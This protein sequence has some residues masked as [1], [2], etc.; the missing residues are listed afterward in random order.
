[1]KKILLKSCILFLF[2][3][4]SSSG[5]FAQGCANTATL[6]AGNLTPPGVGLSTT[7]T[8]NGGQ[9]VLA[10]VIAG[11][12]YTV[13]TCGNTSFDTQL[14]IYNDLS[15]AF[16][17]YNDD[18]CVLQSTVSFTPTFCGNVR[19]VLNQFNCASS[20]SSM[21]VTMTMN[22]AGS[23]IPTL[24]AAPDVQGCNGN[25]VS[26]GIA[27]NGS[28][29]VTPY[30]YQWGPITNLASPT[31]PQT[32][33][34]VTATQSYDLI[35]TDA[36]GCKA[37][38]TVL[39]TM[40]P[41]PNVNLG[42]DTTICGG[43]MLLDAGN[44]GSTY[45]WST[46]QG[47]QTISIS[48]GGTYSV[49][50]QNPSGCINSDAITVVIN[51]NPTVSLGPDTTTC[52]TSVTLNAGPG[53]SSYAWTTGDVTQTSNVTATGPVSVMVTDGNGCSATDTAMVTLSPAPVVN[54]GPDTTQ[55]GGTVTLN[56]GNPG[57]LYF[58]SNSSSSQTTTVNTS[59]TYN[60]QVISPAG[61]SGF[62]TVAVTINNQPV[63]D[64][65][66]DTSICGGS[67]TLDAGNPGDSYLWS[68]FS[69]NETVNV[70]GGTYFVNVTD[71]SGCAGSDTIVVSVNST[72]SVSA[73]SNVSICIGQNTQLTGTGAVNYIWSTGATT[74]SIIVSP[75]INTTYYVTGYDASGCSSSALVTVTVL[76][77]TNALFTGSLTGV[78]E[79][80]TNQSTNAVSY[81][82]NFGDASPANNAENPSHT[83]AANG[84]YT[85]TLTAT[86]PCGSDTY[87]MVVTIS[88]VG[89]Q[90]NDLSNSLSL[91][92]NPNDGN[93]TLSFEFEKTKDVII[94]VLDV[95]GRVVFEDKEDSI[96]N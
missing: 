36:N 67:I 24:T 58:W 75:T 90:D 33:A 82:W 20:T 66:P 92:P 85:V 22:T 34:T 5:A 72:P 23:G 86:G 50:V 44:V 64:L 1:M 56:A 29:G 12:N 18:F 95:S 40:L 42:V 87:T 9:Y 59:G 81:S 14:T 96:M 83:Y 46:G 6:V 84:T 68:T 16:I 62:D 25:T 60:V 70:G 71:P 4:T 45:L 69:T 15:G 61:C 51:P 73:G 54:L 7:Q 53:Y 26:I 11:A 93:F 74:T 8:Y 76:P 57:S 52:G 31:Q 35:L 88:Q 37:Y 27:N 19:V 3:I 77:L 94:Q 43:P 89:L 10:T 47:T 39:V 17:A 32:T 28:G 13:S 65:G 79:T 55:C 80:F 30:A 63:V 49:A 38:D 78:T 91:F 48:S 2:A 41:A 21:D